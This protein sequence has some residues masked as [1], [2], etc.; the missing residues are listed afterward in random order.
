MSDRL[1][2]LASSRIKSAVSMNWWT[3]SPWGPDVGL[4]IKLGARGIEA[5][6]EPPLWNNEIEGI[7]K[8]AA[9]T[10]ER[11]GLIEKPKKSKK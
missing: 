5:V 7:R 9:S 1:A 3:V 11:V 4:P 6:Y 2:Y 8:A 10:R